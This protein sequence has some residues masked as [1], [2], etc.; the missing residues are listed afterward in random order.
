MANLFFNDWFIKGKKL[1]QKI[2]I[3]Q[4]KQNLHTCMRHGINYFFMIPS[5]IVWHGNLNIPLKKTSLF[6]RASCLGSIPILFLKFAIVDFVGVVTK[7]KAPT[8][9]CSIQERVAAT[10]R[11]GLV[12]Y[13]IGPSSHY[14]YSIHNQENMPSKKRERKKGV[15]ERLNDIYIYI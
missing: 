11:G 4:K 8:W 2:S 10:T 12:S 6:F 9:G 7:L 15:C 3:S 5:N 14:A 13:W 1:L